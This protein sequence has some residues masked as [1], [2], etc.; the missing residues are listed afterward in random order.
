M[1]SSSRSQI[2]SISS[3]KGSSY[4]SNQNDN[5]SDS[6]YVP[7]SHGVGGNQ[8][9]TGEELSVAQY[10]DDIEKSVHLN[11]DGSI[12]VE[13]KVRLRIK[14]EET[15]KWTTTVS[16]AGLSDDKNASI[17]NSAIRAEKCLSD[18]NVS[19]RT[20]PKDTPFLKSYKKE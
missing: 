13:M 11:Q 18:V 14:E 15:I 2:F 6:S 5:N 8:L 3:D 20:K 16:R 1:G 9:V 19:E 12:T 10:E 17:C 4:G 7:D